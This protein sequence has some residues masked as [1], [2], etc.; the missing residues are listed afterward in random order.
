MGNAGIGPDRWVNIGDSVEEI[1]SETW[2]AYWAELSADESMEL[3]RNPRPALVADGLIGDDF[4]IETT[5]VNND[6]ESV[7][8]DPHCKVLLVFPHEKLALLTV[9]RHPPGEGK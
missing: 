3:I 5:L 4:R 8:G 6:V 2:D 9:Y 1:G 7:A